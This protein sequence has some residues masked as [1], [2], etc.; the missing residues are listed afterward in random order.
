MPTSS[1]EIVV[2]IRLRQQLTTNY[3]RST[4]R[5]SIEF[6]CRK[7]FTDYRNKQCNSG[8]FYLLLEFARDF[9]HRTVVSHLSY[10]L[11]IQQ[12]FIL[13]GTFLC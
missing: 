1:R 10:V 2:F 5:Q 4:L 7:K 3:H 9:R 13:K 11:L 8:C 6:K 12:N